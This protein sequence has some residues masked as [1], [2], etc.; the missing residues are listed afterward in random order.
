M[1]E[2]ELNTML[3]EMI[4]EKFNEAMNKLVTFKKC[5]NL[6]NEMCAQGYSVPMQAFKNIV[7]YTLILNPNITEDEFLQDFYKK[8]QK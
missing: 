6:Y 3:H 8:M 1:T 2:Q 4:E 7:I 5:E